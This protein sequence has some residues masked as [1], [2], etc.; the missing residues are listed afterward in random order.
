[1][2]TVA[3][4]YWETS[5][6][7]NLL[8]L[9]TIVATVTYAAGFSPPG[10]VW[11][12]TDATAGHLAGEPIIRDT[13]YRGFVMFFYFNATAFASSLGIILFI[14]MLHFLHLPV[15]KWL[16]FRKVALYSFR[17]LM[18]VNLLSLMAAYAAGTAHDTLTAIFS[19]VYVLS[20]VVYILFH[21]VMSLFFRPRE[22]SSQLQKQP[23][24][25]LMLMATFAVGVTYVAGLNAP[26]GFWDNYEG[27]HRPGIA[28]LKGRNDKR[29]NAY[30]F[31]NTTAFTGSLVII[32]Q[33]LD[34]NLR[35]TRRVALAIQLYLCVVLALVGLVCGFVAGSSWESNT[36]AYMIALLVA[37]ST[38]I[39]IQT[40]IVKYF[41]E[42]LKMSYLLNQAENIHD[43]VIQ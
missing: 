6:R 34:T 39:L 36:T 37:I 27:G 13:S 42:A 17:L 10:G 35:T 26:G 14:I 5:L 30:F 33:L 7:E 2:A 41:G 9:A 40:F 16:K 32:V 23:R 25:L 31:F 18:V 19:L 3:K 11:Q 15:G 8:L 43:S 28:V 29:L 22:V 21:T 20:A 24:E 38:C 1:M 4:K 12:D